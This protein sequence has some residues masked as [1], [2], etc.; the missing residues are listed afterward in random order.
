MHELLRWK[1]KISL[2]KNIYNIILKFLLI[3]RKKLHKK[4]IMPPEDTTRPIP[5]IHTNKELYECNM[6]GQIFKH[7]WNTQ[8]TT[9]TATTTS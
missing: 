9:S 5:A 7:N 8:T 6:F 4:K 1:F 2:T 3:S